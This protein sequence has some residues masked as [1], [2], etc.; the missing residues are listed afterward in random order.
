MEN[1]C[2]LVLRSTA[3][4]C[5]EQEDISK[6]RLTRDLLSDG[7]E[8]TGYNTILY[9]EDQDILLAL[10]HQLMGVFIEFV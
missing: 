4:T 9:L 5:D 6:H 7:T 2:I 3:L 1:S 8:L 10:F